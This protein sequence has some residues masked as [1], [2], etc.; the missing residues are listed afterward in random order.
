MQ[1]LSSLLP[2]VSNNSE[3]AAAVWELLVS[4]FSTKAITNLYLCAIFQKM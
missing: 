2:L 3:N 1:Y 4:K